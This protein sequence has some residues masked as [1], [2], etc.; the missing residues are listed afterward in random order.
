MQE[1]AEVSF[2]LNLFQSMDPQGAD[3]LSNVEYIHWGMNAN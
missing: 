1:A 3:S 2:A